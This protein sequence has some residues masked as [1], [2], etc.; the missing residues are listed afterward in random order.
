MMKK[1]F[2]SLAL[3][4]ALLLPLE[5]FGQSTASQE[6]PSSPIPMF[7]EGA[8]WSVSV[9]NIKREWEPGYYH[10][11]N[12]GEN[13]QYGVQGKESF[14]GKEYFHV[15]TT[16]GTERVDFHAR[17][18]GTKVYLYQKSTDREFVLF[19]YAIKPGDKYIGMGGS[20]EN[21]AFYDEFTLKSI[22]TKLIAGE[23]RRVYYFSYKRPSQSHSNTTRGG[24]NYPN[25]SY[26]N[27]HY[28]P[29]N[30]YMSLVWVEGIGTL[31]D[32]PFY[33]NKR[34]TG[35]MPKYLL[36]YTDAKGVQ[37]ALSNQPADFTW[38]VLIFSEST[39][40]DNVESAP[41][42]IHMKEGVLSVDLRDGKLHRLS[43]YSL[44]GVRLLSETSFT[45]SFSA[46][47]AYSTTSFPLVVVLDGKATL[48]RGIER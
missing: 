38:R 19:D 46:Q 18:E 17:E 9:K 4:T 10:W 39:A 3:L 21:E 13:Y 24:Y 5:L 11:V 7:A 26:T 31:E 44:D 15:V 12:E 14:N 42:S 32:S 41:A 45:G 35:S 33:T 8:K 34:M 23:N 48:Y 2:H 30:A 43:V 36:G 1:L 25:I 16:K 47:L 6:E 29:S 20:P 27:I 40:L 37:H 28:S 22:E